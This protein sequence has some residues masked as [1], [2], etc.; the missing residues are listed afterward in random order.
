[1]PRCALTLCLS[2]LLLA[3]VIAVAQTNK[4][5]GNPPTKPGTGPGNPGVGPGGAG[6][7]PMKPIG[8]LPGG[9]LPG[10]GLP[11]GG[12]PGGGGPGAPANPMNP[13]APGASKPSTPSSPGTGAGYQPP[14]QVLDHDLDWWIKKL[15]P[16]TN[17]DAAVRELA[18][19]V[20]PVFGEAAAKGKAMPKVVARLGDPDPA[21]KF[22]A[23]MYICAYT[24]EEPNLRNSALQR[25]FGG[26]DSTLIRST[27]DMLR[28]ASVNAAAHI[29]PPAAM[30]IPVLMD[31]IQYPTSYEMRKAAAIALG[32]VAREDSTKA[33]LT[34]AVGG[35]H[36][37][38]PRAIRALVDR[39]GDHCLA[40][41]VEV[42]RSLLLLGRP[43]EE[44][45][46]VK[47]REMLLSRVKI[48]PDSGLKL[49][50]RVCL[51]RIAD[52]AP[53]D[54][55]LDPIAEA[56]RNKDNHFER[57]CAAQ[58]LGVLG[59]SAA[60]KAGALKVGLEF[61]NSEKPEDREFLFMCLW[62]MGRMGAKASFM[63]QDIQALAT[64]HPD[65]AVK[66][67]AKQTLD[68][69]QGRAAP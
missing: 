24:I 17:T 39:L 26:S 23:L 6:N 42:A 64:T 48:E 9:G 68:K 67:M 37:P 22:A 25:I 7:P 13:S 47:E 61:K 46:V 30:S 15:D 21:V 45:D 31:Y 12:I 1:M 11:G 5:G 69:V 3:P 52:S 36:G 51:I 16:Q 50:L 38:D 55:E 66:D 44:K 20:I 43:G 49:W 59:Q 56:L 19:R 35:P 60:S 34:G 18:I 41:R 62:A 8:G 32:Q 10:G 53:T 4:P 63:Q 29:G 14:S 65:A 58:A 57:L 28:L 27:N 40:V 2:I 33:M 54:K